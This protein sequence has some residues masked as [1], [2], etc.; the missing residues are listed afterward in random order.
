MYGRGPGLFYER[1][2]SLR[3]GIWQERCSPLT[4]QNLHGTNTGRNLHGTNTGRNLH[5]TNTG[6]LQIAI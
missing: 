1:N 5:G 4:V 6:R 2:Y 3:K